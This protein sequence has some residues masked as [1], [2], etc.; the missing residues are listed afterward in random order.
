MIRQQSL[1]A[2]A[3]TAA[4]IAARSAAE[5][6]RAPRFP[7]EAFQAIKAQRLLGIQVPEGL[8][9]EGAAVRDVADVCFRL[10]QACS[11]TGMIYAMHQVKIGCLARHGQ[12]SAAIRKLLGRICSEQLLLASSTTEGQGGGTVPGAARDRHFLWCGSRRYR[13]HCAANR[14]RRAVRSGAG[15]FSQE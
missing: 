3:Q 7:A 14:R 10:G 11:S 15:G 5:V 4:A 9:G 1:A 2:R 8:G 6:D 12:A 13:H